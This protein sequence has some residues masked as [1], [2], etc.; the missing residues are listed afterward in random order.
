MLT[1]LK[2]RNS[3]ARRILAATEAINMVESEMIVSR[4]G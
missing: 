1:E 2:I 4:A 3:M